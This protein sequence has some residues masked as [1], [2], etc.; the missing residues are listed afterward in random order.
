MFKITPFRQVKWPVTISVPQDG[1][2]VQKHEIT[3]RFDILP[4]SRLDDLVRGQRGADEDKDLLREVLLGWDGVADED[5]VAIEFA[6]APRDQLL[7][8]PY[9]RG[10]LLKAYFEAA[11][12]S[13]A[14][15]KN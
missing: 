5:G 1:G 2:R 15:R 9:V 12:G 11:S 13:A 8:I 4:Q 7:D 14:A 10:A 6:D 3:A